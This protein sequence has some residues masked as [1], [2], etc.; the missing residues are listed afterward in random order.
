MG[1]LLF[2]NTNRFNGI[3]YVTLCL[4]LAALGVGLT[5]DHTYVGIIFI[6]LGLWGAKFFL[7]MATQRAEF[8]EQGFRSKS[9]YGELSGRY[10]DLKSIMRMAVV[11]N[12][13]L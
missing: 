3:A 1:K 13:V 6:P 2:V 5:W 9:I 10:A 8:Y 11:R 4:A 12:G 7:K